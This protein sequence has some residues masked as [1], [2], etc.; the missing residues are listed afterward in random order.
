M[1]TTDYTCD[2]E[3]I[4]TITINNP[5]R[6]NAMTYPMIEELYESFTIATNEAR[7]VILTGAE[8]TFCSG[9][10]LNFLENIPPSERGI[11]IPTYDEDGW[12]NITSCPLPVIA[13]VD[14]AAVGM[15]AEW[16]SHCDIRIATTR[17][18]FS[19]NFSH[20]GLIPDTGAGT[21]LL[22]RQIGT[23]NALQLLYS[24][25]WLD[26]Q[27]ALEIGY[28]YKTVE[29][30]LLLPTAIEEARSYLLGAPSSHRMT[31][32][33]LYSGLYRDVAKHQEISRRALLECFQ[34]DDHQEGLTAF[35]EGR[36]PDFK[37]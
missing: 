1:G 36:P 20:R 12:W 2:E 23:Q 17:A 8:D 4:A 11:K 15:G 35:T 7:V 22:P 27:R 16:T 33:L 10:D 32:K 31:K 25:T 21:W 30:D 18:R 9:I 3:G 13:A 28:V 19:W 34:S 26:A 24:G 37:L 29:P 6:R 5:N 14:G